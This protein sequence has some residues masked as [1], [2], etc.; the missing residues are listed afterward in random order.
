M[1]NAVLQAIAD[2]RSIRGYE[3]G[4]LSPEHV[5]ALVLAAEQAPTARNSQIWHFSVV[6]DTALI[7]EINGE[8]GKNAGRPGTD[9]FYGAPLAIFI[10]ADPQSRY[11][12]LDSGIAVEN[13]ALAAHALGLGSVILGMPREA[14]AG[15]RREE[16]ERALR[17]PAGYEFQIAIAVGVPTMTKEAHEIL[18]GRVDYIG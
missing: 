11:A 16:F 7:A 18:P 1:S 3:P 8:I 5:E 4:R 9:F 13:I 14:F 15:D 17:F 12:G 6:Q 10:S 2:R